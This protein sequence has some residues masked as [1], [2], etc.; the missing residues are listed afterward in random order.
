MDNVV[1]E[2]AEILT[3]PYS[4]FR[5][6]SKKWRFFCRNEECEEPIR[7]SKIDRQLVITVTRDTKVCEGYKAKVLYK[8]AMVRRNFGL[9]RLVRK[10]WRLINPF[11]LSGISQKVYERIYMAIYRV[12]LKEKSEDVP[13][14]YFVRND[15]VVDFGDRTWLGFAGFY[16]G[17][18][19]FLDSCAYGV[20][21]TEYSLIMK[22]INN[23]LVDKK[24]SANVN[25]FS[26]IHTSPDCRVQYHPWMVEMVK[27][28]DHRAKRPDEIPDLIKAPSEFRVSDRLLIRKPAKPIDRENFNVI[29]LEKMMS[30]Q[31]LKEYKQ[32]LRTITQSHTRIKI[33]DKKMHTFYSN[34]LEKISP[35]SSLLK[36]NRS[37]S[38]VLEKVIDGRKTLNFK[39]YSQK[40]LFL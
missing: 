34:H 5:I 37:R 2:E 31:L 38:N 32:G 30:Q 39:S 25:L 19:E 9:F 10:L 11:N 33:Q 12:V 13:I 4:K 26:K 28:E 1:M 18:F 40:D 24:W 35:L 36:Q 8:R 17:L 6:N 23:A 20:L 27:A 16:D 22:N 7:T 15:R 14:E 3:R 21:S 29:K